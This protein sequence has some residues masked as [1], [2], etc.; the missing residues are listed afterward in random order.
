MDLGGEAVAPRPLEDGTAADAIVALLVAQGVETFFGIPGGPV[1]PVFDAIF[2]HP[3]ARL[4]QSRHEAAAAFSATA[5][6]RASGKVAAVV[7]TAGPGATNAVTGIASAHFEGVPVVLIV[8]DVAWAADGERLLQ[9]SGRE[10]LDV[11]GMFGTITRRCVRVSKPASAAA[12]ASAVVAAASDPDHPGPAML[13]VPIHLAAAPA[14]AMRVVGTG[15]ASSTTVDRSIVQD[16]CRRL[17]EAERPLLVLGAGARPFADAVRDVVETLRIPFVTTPKAKGL[18]PETHLA[19]L[20]NGGLAA[21]AWAREYTAAGVDMALVLGTDLDDCSIGPTPYV[22]AGGTLVHV[23]R[24][25]TVFGRNLPTR[26]GVVADVGTFVE[27]MRA[28]TTHHAVTHRRAFDELARL[29]E[30]SPFVQAPYVDHDAARVH[31]ADAIVSL[32]AAAGPGVAFTTDI[33]EHMLF[34]LHYLTIDAP[35]AFQIQLGLGSMGSGIGGA[36][37]LALADPTRLVVCICGDGGMQMAGMEILVAAR[38]RLP[39]AFAVF[40]DGR[41]NMVHHGFA[42]VFGHDAPWDSHAIDFA[43]WARS[44][45]VTGHRIDDLTQ[46]CAERLRGPRAGEGP[47][48]LDIRIDPD[49][50]M[51]GGG[52]NEAL[53]HMSMLAR[54]TDV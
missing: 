10:G 17:A 22:S 39:I 36:I 16:T 34:A 51:A 30:R 21:S 4:V 6:G 15:V 12:Q 41:Y 23:D 52:R 43:A 50:R 18:L 48:V 24:D 28:V 42:Q 54:G 5:Y 3:R 25:A 11:E 47:V 27:A 32:Q 7:V 26:T 14:S 49:I 38:E 2:R 35:D 33:G 8:G 9:S 44:I 29:R 37:G 45:G 46:I 40:N 19:S 31:P 13:V 1:S 20:R 53:Q